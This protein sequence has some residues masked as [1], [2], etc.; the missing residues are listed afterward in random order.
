[1][2]ILRREHSSFPQAPNLPR[3]PISSSKCFVRPL[4]HSAQAIKTIFHATLG[5]ASQKS[6][7][8]KYE[9]SVPQMGGSFKL[10]QIW[11]LQLAAQKLAIATN[12]T[13]LCSIHHYKCAR[14][15]NWNGFTRRWAS[16]LQNWLNILNANMNRPPPSLLAMCQGARVSSDRFARNFAS[17]KESLSVSEGGGWVPWRASQLPL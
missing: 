17:S 2:K 13:S 10:F 6:R 8:F 12:F 5:A 16:P 11:F 15:L 3:K 14:M 4:P 9:L 7:P 1:M